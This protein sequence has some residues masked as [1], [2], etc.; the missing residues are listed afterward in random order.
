MVPH[1]SGGITVADYLNDYE[2]E[3]GVDV[4]GKVK[5]HIR[6]APKGN[7]AFYRLVNANAAEE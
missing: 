1:P 7:R 4:E 6:V 2:G 3:G 5:V